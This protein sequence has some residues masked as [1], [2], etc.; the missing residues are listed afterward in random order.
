MHAD[1]RLLYPPINTL[2]PVT[3]DIWIVDGPII[4]LG[5]PWPRMPFPTRMTVIRL[6]GGLL[7]HSPTPLVPALRSEIEAL[8]RPRWIIAPN[9]LHYWW[10]RDWHAGFP[11]A[12]IYLAPR[13]REQAGERIQFAAHDLSGES[14]F[15]W[16]EE[17][18]TLPVVGRFMTEIELFHHASRTLIL[19]DLIESFEPA[20]LGN[21]LMRWLAWA[22]GVLAPSG[23][24]PRDMRLSFRRS[25]LANAVQTMIAWNPERI[26]LAHGR[27]C[28]TG[29]RAELERAFRWLLV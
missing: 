1:D 29:G 18:K 24:M 25:V 22:G 21:A 28:E 3:A 11:D 26:L 16:D 5:M 19:T 27:W 15:A 14:G 10:V 23:S 9:R 7:I 17:L 2:K 12:E 13:V 4:R 8:G 20:R 6:A